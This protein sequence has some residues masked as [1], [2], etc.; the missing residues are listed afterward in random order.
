MRQS[1]ARVSTLGC[2]CL[3]SPGPRGL[4]SRALSRVTRI[5]RWQGFCKHPLHWVL[6]TSASVFGSLI[7]GCGDARGRL[8]RATPRVACSTPARMGIFLLKTPQHAAQRVCVWGGR[9]GKQGVSTDGVQ[10]R[11]LAYVCLCASRCSSSKSRAA[12]PKIN[13]GTGTVAAWL[14]GRRLTIGRAAIRG[15]V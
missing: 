7:S 15:W 1:S 3:C 4:V 14:S 11:G 2:S 6:A 8:L 12:L 13:Q 9:A 5:G 10:S